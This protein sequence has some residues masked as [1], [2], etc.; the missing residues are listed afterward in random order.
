MFRY[1]KIGAN[2]TLPSGELN[3]LFRTLQLPSGSLWRLSEGCAAVVPRD[4][5]MDNFNLAQL[6]Q[7]VEKHFKITSR[8]W[9][10]Q[11]DPSYLQTSLATHTA[12]RAV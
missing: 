4:Y 12:G 9:T 2:T 6:A 5:I 3:Q 10:L 7:V 1:L 11:V 8:A